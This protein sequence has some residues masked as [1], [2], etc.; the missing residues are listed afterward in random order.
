MPTPVMQQSIF[1]ELATP[2]KIPKRTAQGQTWTVG[3]RHQLHIGSSTIDA[4]RDFLD[5]C[6]GCTILTDPPYSSGGFQAAQ[7]TSSQ[8]KDDHRVGE[9]RGDLLSVRGFQVLL[10]EAIAPAK[11]QAL[12][13]FT[14]WR[15]WH[16]LWDVAE[17][18]LGLRVR[19]MIV[20]DKGNPGMGRGWR[21]QH[22]IIMHA[23]SETSLWPSGW[24]GSGN[25][26]AAPR[27]KNVWHTTEKPLELIGRLV[28]NSPFADMIVDPFVGSG[29]TMLA[30][31][32]AGKQSRGLELS[33]V[34][35]DAALERLRLLTDTEPER[36]A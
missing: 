27:S 17:G 14:D 8:G 21:A 31:E 7:K 4:A 10:R 9:L 33:P 3:E 13:C 15:M 19:S 16:H 26:L 36:I 25:V 24:P 23:D 34:Y 22:E 32:L 2:G 11:P 20:W 28:A 35:A 5:G 6:A 12:Y 29:T 18:M 1:T 30:A